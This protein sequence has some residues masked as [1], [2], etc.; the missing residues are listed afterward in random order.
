MNGLDAGALGVAGLFVVLFLL[1]LA[2]LWFLMP[3][4][5]MGTNGR[6]DRMLKNQA[7]IIELLEKRQP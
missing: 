5:V 3:F 4:L 6:L 2:V 7:R 1:L